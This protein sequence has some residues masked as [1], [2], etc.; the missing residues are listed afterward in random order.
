MTPFLAQGSGYNWDMRTPWCTRCRQFSV[1][2]SSRT[3]HSLIP[4][5]SH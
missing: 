4:N 5:T 2:Q 1:S 3:Y